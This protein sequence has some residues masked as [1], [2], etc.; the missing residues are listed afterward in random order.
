MPWVLKYCISNNLST[1]RYNFNA[2]INVGN[3]SMFNICQFSVT[4]QIFSDDGFLPGSDCLSTDSLKSF[5]DVRGDEEIILEDGG[6]GGD[7]SSSD[8]AGLGG[9]ASSI[10]VSRLDTVSRTMDLSAI[11]TLPRRPITRSMG[12]KEI[13][14]VEHG[15]SKEE[16]E[17]G[18]GVSRRS[19]RSEDDSRP[20]LRLVRMEARASREGDSEAREGWE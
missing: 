20:G 12:L 19:W 7:L 17:E 15:E 2:T 5:L 13:T 1:F 8:T 4:M 10:K 6:P 9:R 3:L 11:V 18:E 14:L 16:V